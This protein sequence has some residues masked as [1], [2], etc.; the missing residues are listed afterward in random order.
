MQ[1]LSTAGL[2]D[3][4][5]DDGF[6]SA[7]P[8]TSLSDKSR[9]SQSRISHISD[10]C[11]LAVLVIV[12]IDV[13]GSA[14]LPDSLHR[15]PAGAR[16]AAV[17]VDRA[18]TG[19]HRPPQWG[20]VGARRGFRGSARGAVRNRRFRAEAGPLP[21]GPDPTGG[22]AAAPGLGPG[23]SESAGRGRLRYRTLHYANARVIPPT[24]DGLSV[25]IPIRGGS[26]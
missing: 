6:E 15:K 19:P 22:S 17:E 11:S 21:W 3:S 2:A 7:S 4:D 26:S 13:Y 9:P 20:S 14:N 10:A 24:D 8:S 5:P 1:A 12:I 18:S 25:S 16:R 23:L